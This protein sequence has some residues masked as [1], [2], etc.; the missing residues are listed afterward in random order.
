VTSCAK[1]WPSP[2]SSMGYRL[3]WSF[4]RARN[5]MR[6]PSTPRRGSGIK[7]WTPSWSGRRRQHR[8]VA[9]V[10]AGTAIPLGILPLG[11]LNHFARDLG[12]PTTI[13]DAVTLIASR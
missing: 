7:S 8:T 10:M 5:C 4:W 6:P 9:H 3:L 2:L 11:T 1:R 13:A 12:I